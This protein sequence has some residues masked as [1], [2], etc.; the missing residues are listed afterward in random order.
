MEQWVNS[1]VG[2]IDDMVILMWKREQKKEEEERKMK[3]RDARRNHYED[4]VGRF[5]VINEEFDARIRNERVSSRVYRHSHDILD[6]LVNY[7]HCIMF[8]TP[9][10]VT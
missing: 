5:R 7:M 3:N 9:L 6:D 1:G 10:L 8:S 2:N 4:V